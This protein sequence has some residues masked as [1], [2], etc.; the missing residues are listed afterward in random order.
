MIS[1]DTA[2]IVRHIKLRDNSK[3]IWVFSRDRGRY[4]LMVHG[5][6]SRK[7]SPYIRLLN[8]IEF[9]TYKKGNFISLH[10]ISK[11]YDFIIIDKLINQTLSLYIANII[12]KIVPEQYKSETVYDYI[13]SVLHTLSEKSCPLQS[14]IDIQQKFLEI[15]ISDLGISTSEEVS[16]H[17]L[18]EEELG[19]S[20]WNPFN[21]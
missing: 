2:I 8:K 21:K 16:F 14:A 10:S 6:Y 1:T 3:I 11:S 5:A 19:Y 12:C 20:V 15:I 17:K 4:A 18:I 13:E 7:I 9:S